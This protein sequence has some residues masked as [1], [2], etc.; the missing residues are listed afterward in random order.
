[1]TA[2]FS[3]AEAIE[4]Y[5]RSKFREMN[6]F[7]I[8]LIIFTVATLY[9]RDIPESNTLITSMKETLLRKRFISADINAT[10]QFMDINSEVRQ[11]FVVT[12]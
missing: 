6:L 11:G 1:M 3:V 4:A 9:A 8:F 5:R 10:L 2:T 12:H 7:A